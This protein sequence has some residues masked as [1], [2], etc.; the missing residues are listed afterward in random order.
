MSMRTG[1]WLALCGMLAMAPVFAAEIDGFKG[2][3]QIDRVRGDDGERLLLDYRSRTRA[4][5]RVGLQDTN[6]SG[7]DASVVHRLADAMANVSP[8]AG[9]DGYWHTRFG[10]DSPVP[11]GERWRVRGVFTEYLA[12]SRQSRP[13]DVSLDAGE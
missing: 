5:L 10:F 6:V 9:D 12:G 13:F 2:V 4:V 8:R 3:L 7:D 1:C 11:A